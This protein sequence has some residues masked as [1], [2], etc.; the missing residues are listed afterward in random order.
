MERS[1]EEGLA[2]DVHRSGFWVPRSEAR[3]RGS[4][5]RPN[6]SR[7][8][9]FGGTRRIKRAERG[10]APKLRGAGQKVILY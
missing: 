5:H 8:G 3:F 10:Q 4:G 2:F 1:R 6:S 9:A 7:A